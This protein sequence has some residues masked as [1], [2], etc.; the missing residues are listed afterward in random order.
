MQHFYEK[1]SQI[2]Y[3]WQNKNYRFFDRLN[4]VSSI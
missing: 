2:A 1:K 3:N 4:N